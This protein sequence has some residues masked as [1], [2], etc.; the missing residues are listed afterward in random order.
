MPENPNYITKTI[1]SIVKYSTC[2]A[3][4]VAV[5]MG[6]YE[7]MNLNLSGIIDESARPGLA[8]CVG[9]LWAGMTAGLEFCIIRPITSK[10]NSF[11]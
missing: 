3:L 5:G 8:A 2:I 11:K 1:E 7:F 6:A 9:L 10:Q 4:P